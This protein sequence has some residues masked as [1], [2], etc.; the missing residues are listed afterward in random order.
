MIVLNDPIKFSL[1]DIEIIEEHYHGKY[2]LEICTKCKGGGWSDF[3][4]TIFYTEKAHPQGSNYFLL[5]NNPYEG[6]MITDGLPAIK[7]P[8]KGLLIDGAIIYSRYR[9]DY[10]EYNGIIVDGGRDYFRIGGERMNIA[11]EVDIVVVKDQIHFKF[12]NSDNTEL[13]EATP[14]FRHPMKEKNDN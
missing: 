11:Q 14:S 3:A 12:T 5:Y 9:H 6:L 4:G 8:I 2:L 10:R 13:Y 1:E 7:D